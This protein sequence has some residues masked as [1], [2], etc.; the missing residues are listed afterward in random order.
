MYKKPVRTASAKVRVRVRVRIQFSTTVIYINKL[1]LQQ[2]FNGYHAYT[3]HTSTIT[4][5]AAVK[6]IQ[7]RT[8]WAKGREKMNLKKDTRKTRIRSNFLVHFDWSEF[9]G[10]MSQRGK[11]VCSSTAYTHSSSSSSLLFVFH[12]LSLCLFVSFFPFWPLSTLSS[13][14]TWLW[15][16]WIYE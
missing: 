15:Y 10:Q 2:L 9:D 14:C 7:Y 13:L 5:T 4:A 16:V 8:S 6:W 12:S 11:C 3:L 1:Q